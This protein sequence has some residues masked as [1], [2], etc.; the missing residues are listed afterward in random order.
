[1]RIHADVGPRKTAAVQQAGVVLAVG[2]DRVAGAG[3]G[4]DGAQVGGESGREEQGRFGA[5]EFGQPLFQLLMTL[6]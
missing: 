2:E 3:Q 6:A 5:F 1:M 4:G